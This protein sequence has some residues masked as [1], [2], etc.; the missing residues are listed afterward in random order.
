MRRSPN[1]SRRNQRVQE[2]VAFLF[3]LTEGLF[4]RCYRCRARGLFAGPGQRWLQTLVSFSDPHD[5]FDLA[6]GLSDLG[7]RWDLCQAKG[8]F[9]TFLS[10]L[11]VATWDVVYPPVFATEGEWCPIGRFWNCPRDPQKLRIS[12]GLWYCS[13][14]TGGDPPDPQGQKFAT[15]TKSTATADPHFTKGSSRLQA[16]NCLC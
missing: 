14:H 4:R 3:S 8:P 2:A 15:T 12:R 11:G 7:S 16:E 10:S 9:L 13:P 6:E 1:L 5:L